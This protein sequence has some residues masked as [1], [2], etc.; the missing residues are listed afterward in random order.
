MNASYRT[1]GFI[2]K[3][4]DRLEADCWLTV[5][6]QDFGRIVILAR[7]LRKINSKLRS[8]SPLFSFLEI[9]FVQGKNRKTL[10]DARIIIDFPSTKREPEKLKVAYKMAS[11]FEESIKGEEQDALLLDHIKESFALLEKEDSLKAD[12]VGEYFFWN[13]M[14]ILG[15]AP[16]LKKC[17]VCAGALVE[18][19]LYF[20]YQDGGILCASCARVKKGID[21][22]SGDVIKIIRLCL[23]RD[24]ATIGRLKISPAI[25]SAMQIVSKKYH[26]YLDNHPIKHYET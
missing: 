22:I 4:E 10:T 25:L 16:E 11:V 15:Y 7:A 21:K 3:K 20:S 6:T 9:E 13:L 1:Q 12:A 24:W 26:I 23:A 8:Q 19:Q 2:F 5:F 17:V 18:N 14:A